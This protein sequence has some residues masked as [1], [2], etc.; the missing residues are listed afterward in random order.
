MTGAS[1][2]NIS[3]LQVDF[4]DQ[5]VRELRSALEMEYDNFQVLALPTCLLAVTT[6]HGTG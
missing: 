4:F 1:V 6:P 5:T 2:V 3:A